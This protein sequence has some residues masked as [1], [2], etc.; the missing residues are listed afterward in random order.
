MGIMSMKEIKEERRLESIPKIVEVKI[1]NICIAEYQRTPDSNEI[2]KIQDKFDPRM[3]G[4]GL[5][6]KRDGKYFIV[7]GNTRKTAM[8]SLGYKQMS[9]MLVEGLDYSEEA[10]LFLKFNKNR[11]NLNPNQLFFAEVEAKHEKA[12]DMVRIFNKRG[13]KYNRHD[14]AKDDYMIGAIASCR[15]VYKKGAEYLDTTLEVIKNSWGGQ[16]DALSGNIIKGI[17]MFILLY[18]DVYNVDTLV[19]ILGK[20]SPSGFENQAKERANVRK[21]STR[22]DGTC[23]F[24]AKDIWERYQKYTGIKLDY[25][26]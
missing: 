10:D 8:K 3:V 12:L 19:N 26:F 4:I 20:L 6:S 25:R 9:V 18:K 17:G 13:F 16:K 7:D 21:F 24:I 23:K 2:R 14:G 22:R 11:K 15:F 5:V 1:D